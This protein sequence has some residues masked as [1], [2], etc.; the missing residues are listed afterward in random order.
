MHKWEIAGRQLRLLVAI[1][2]TG[3]DNPETKWVGEAF[4]MWRVNI[5]LNI[6]LS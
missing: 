3:K 5:L 1:P 6:E 2:I 4:G